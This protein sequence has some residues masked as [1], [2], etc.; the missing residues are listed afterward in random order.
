MPTTIKEGYKLLQATVKEETIERFDKLLAE[1]QKNAPQDQKKHFRNRGVFIDW[2]IDRIYLILEEHHRI[3]QEKAELEKKLELL[4]EKQEELA[5]REEKLA[6]ANIELHK[7]I[8]FLKEL[9]G[10]G[11][12]KNDIL[13]VAKILKD[14]E[15]E[16]S[17]I[18]EAIQ[19]AGGMLKWLKKVTATY[20]ELSQQLAELNEEIISRKKAIEQLKQKE[21]E[22]KQEIENRKSEFERA[23][24]AVA[25]SCAVARDVGLYID[26]INK[27]CEANGANTIHELMLKPALV[28]AGV[29][30]EAAA[31]AYGDTE[32]T[33]IPGPK[34]L[35]PMQVT[36]RE[37]A[38]SLA[39]PEAYQEQLRAQAKMQAQT[40]LLTEQ[41]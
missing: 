23:T 7:G 26:Y 9:A 36:I 40:E 21:E 4:A 20:E 39:P 10:T 38:R 32:I 41:A 11:V 34:H 24:L 8:R 14:A 27:I 37:I 29:I 25:Q 22:I 30:L 31:V 1:L 6:E 15:L 17:E 35:L 12:T 5:E 2:L 18:V 13:A 33:L 3:L 16:P 28:I 19:N